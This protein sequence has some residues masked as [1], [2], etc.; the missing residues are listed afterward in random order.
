[1]QKCGMELWQ[2]CQKPYKGRYMIIADSDATVRASSWFT[3]GKIGR[4]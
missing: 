4:D 2:V 3:P 1:M